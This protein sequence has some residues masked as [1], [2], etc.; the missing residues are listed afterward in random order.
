MIFI[1]S[2]CATLLGKEFQPVSK[3]RCEKLDM[4][5]L[6]QVD[7]TEAF[8]RGTK[9]DW[10]KQDCKIF[11]VTIDRKAYDEGY[12]KGRDI[13]CSCEVAYMAGVKEEILEIKAMYYSCTDEQR[14]KMKWA[15]DLGDKAKDDLTLLQKTST[16]KVNYFDDK[17]EAR[18]KEVCA[19]PAG[20]Q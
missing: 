7:A 20:L 1:F 11:G 4:R 8:T 10:W 13:Y 3:E 17:I 15:H 9:Y 18:A 12:D 14:T 5:A 16:L 2:A 19:P 6:G